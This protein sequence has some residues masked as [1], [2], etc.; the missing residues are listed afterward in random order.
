[1]GGC[2]VISLPCCV[3]LYGK[4][5][6]LAAL[7]KKDSLEIRFG[8]GRKLDGPTFVRSVPV[9]GRMYKNCFEIRSEKEIDKKFISWMKESYQL[10]EV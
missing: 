9:S 4:Y 10:R 7:P 6:F 5:D 1:V 3:H 8:L 2:K